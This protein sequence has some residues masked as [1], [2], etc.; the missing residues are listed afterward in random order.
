MGVTLVGFIVSIILARLLAPDDF[1][2]I[3][4]VVVFV[5]L[6]DI[7]VDCGFGSALIQKES[8]DNLDFS[9]VF[10]FTTVLSIMLGA[11]LFL[12]APAIAAFYYNPQLI[13][14][15]RWMSFRKIF[16]G[17]GK[18]QSAYAYRNMLF[19][20]FFWSSAAA[21][22]VSA[23]VAIVM[24]Y[25]GYGIWALVAQYL[26]S[27]GV[28]TVVLWFTIKWRP[29]PAFS[30]QRLKVLYSFGWKL[31]VSILIATFYTQLR[32]LIIGKLYTTE[33]LAYYTR[34]KNFPEL[35]TDN[36]T[37]TIANVLFPAVSQKQKDTEAMKMMVRQSMTTTAYLVWPAMAGL[38]VCAEPLVLL[39]LTEKW[40]PAVPFLQIACFVNALTPIQYANSQVIKAM[41]RSDIFLKLEIVKRSIAVVI[42]LLIM[43][44]GVWIIALSSILTGTIFLVLNTVPTAR[45][46]KYRFTE[47]MADI[48]PSLGLS[49][50]MA[51]AVYPIHF[52]ELSAVPTLCLQAAT[53]IVVYVLLSLL[54]KVKS[55]YFI[56]N[57]VRQ[58][59]LSKEKAILPDDIKTIS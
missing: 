15:I 57:T 2:L 7:I 43:H 18:A 21:T 37:N 40:L 20:R 29:D 26:I 6:T 33:D 31:M 51:A 48:L 39:L 44:Q 50:L 14:I 1:G 19:K 42:L 24:A 41:G 55:F 27:S 47:Q 3:A 23:V 49:A 10:Y 11:V 54:F 36:F 46:I 13:P 16:N 58:F 17:I 4:I 5:I 8:V 35:I 52:L 25:S 22:L 12:A 30:W 53:G 9:T 45:L 59:L 38:A 28:T 32:S 34:G 56:L